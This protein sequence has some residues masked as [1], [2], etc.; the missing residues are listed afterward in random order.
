MR[1]GA[2]LLLVLHSAAPHVSA[3][4]TGGLSPQASASRGAASSRLIR[5]GLQLPD[6][7]TI[8]TRY[9][10]PSPFL[11]SSFGRAGPRSTTYAGVQSVFT[12]SALGGGSEG[13]KPAVHCQEPI[14]FAS[15]VAELSDSDW[16]LLTVD[17]AQWD[18][19]AKGAGGGDVFD[20]GRVHAL[21]QTEELGRVLLHGERMESTQARPDRNLACLRI[22]GPDLFSSV[23]T[24][25][26]QGHQSYTISPVTAPHTLNRV[27]MSCTTC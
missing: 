11:A 21:L 17:G 19:F 10:L 1:L 12:M 15:F 26:G 25:L 20:A 14:D 23:R 27:M 7:G 13:G 16:D 18:A 2:P 9:I 5:R 4:H 8:G 6:P 3:F 22:L 24:T